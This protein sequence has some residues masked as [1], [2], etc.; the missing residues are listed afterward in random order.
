MHGIVQVINCMGN[1][2]IT[3]RLNMAITTSIRL[4]ST[5]VAKEHNL[6]QPNP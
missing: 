3:A 2:W 4:R 5:R 6:S 1:Y